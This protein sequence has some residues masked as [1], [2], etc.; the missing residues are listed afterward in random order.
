MGKWRDDEQAAERSQEELARGWHSAQELFRSLQS[1]QPLSP[2][3]YASGL[4]LQADELEYAAADAE[5]CRF[6]GLDGGSYVHSTLLMGGP[7]MMAATGIASAVGN[8]SRRTAA[9][10]QAMPQWRYGGRTRAVLTSTR[11]L[12]SSEGQW[13]SFYHGA[14]LELQ[15]HPATSSMFMAFEGT[16]PLSLR[17]PWIPYLSVALFYLLHGRTDPRTVELPS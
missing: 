7:F 5:F 11:L 6:Y 4:L 12:I 17:G 16:S 3:P 8:R 1:G 13:L 15:P 9:E 2:L 10:V 14:I